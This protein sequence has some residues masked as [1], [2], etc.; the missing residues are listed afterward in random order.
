M[1]GSIEFWIE[2]Y[3]D[4]QWE[5]GHLPV[6]KTV[7]LHLMMVGAPTY[8]WCGGLAFV[9]YLRMLRG[10]SEPGLTCLD[11]ATVLGYR[12]FMAKHY[13]VHRARR[14]ITALRGFAS[15]CAQN[16]LFVSEI[17]LSWVGRI[18]SLEGRRS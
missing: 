11:T 5:L 10:V 2:K 16:H 9:Q 15:W 3:L 8:P 4:E 13:D 14:H 1:K 7:R 6:R 18:R 17:D 12:D